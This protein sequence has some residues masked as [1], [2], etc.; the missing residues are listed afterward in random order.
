[1]LGWNHSLRTSRSPRRTTHVT[2]GPGPP[3]I[4]VTDLWTLPLLPGPRRPWLEPEKDVREP[5]HTRGHSKQTTILSI[6][7][8]NFVLSNKM[9]F[10]SDQKALVSVILP[11]CIIQ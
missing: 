6:Q 1:M 7:K 2:Q 10:I 9:P 11:I 5:Q 4:P 3:A 8:L